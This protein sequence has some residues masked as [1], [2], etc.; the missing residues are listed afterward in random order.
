MLSRLYLAQDRWGDAADILNE[1]IISGSI[2][3]IAEM[4]DESYEKL[5]RDRGEYSLRLFSVSWVLRINLQIPA[6][7][8]CIL[9]VLMVAG[10]SLLLTMTGK[11]VFLYGWKRY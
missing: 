10:I 7:N 8:I 5:F 9:N 1:V 2:S 4:V 3:L 11:R 6:I